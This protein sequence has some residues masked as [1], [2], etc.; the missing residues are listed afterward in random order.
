[1]LIRQKRTQKE[2]KRVLETKQHTLGVRR[3]HKRIKTPY[4]LH[5]GRNRKRQEPSGDY[6]A[7][8]E[9]TGPKRGH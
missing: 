7:K 8:F 6:V 4:R 3:I 1:M 5:E 9:R 2:N